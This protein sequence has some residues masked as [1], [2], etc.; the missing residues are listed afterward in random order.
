MVAFFSSFSM[1]L[2]V[3]HEVILMDLRNPELPVVAQPWTSPTSPWP[4][5][6]CRVGCRARGC[7]QPH[8]WRTYPE[9]R[10]CALHT[11]T[12]LQY[13]VRMPTQR[14]CRCWAPGS[15]QVDG[16]LNEHASLG[17]QTGLRSLCYPLDHLLPCQLTENGAGASS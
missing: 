6:A 2:P 16:K 13:A 11:H 14:L 9:L 15:C 8:T 5:A 4:T 3:F 7:V 12:P 10:V 17:S 1:I